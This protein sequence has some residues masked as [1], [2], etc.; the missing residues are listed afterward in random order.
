MRLERGEEVVSKLKELADKENIKLASLRAIGAVDEI[1]LGWYD[2]ENQEY[3][4]KMLHGQWEITSL[5]GSI[6]TMQGEPYLHLHI[7]VSNESYQAMGGHLESA[8]I[9]GSFEGIIWEHPG[10]VER[11]PDPETG[12]NVLKLSD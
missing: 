5:M 9:S 2:V 1:T 3:R 7:T 6:T 11:V 10:T 12:L 4:S 8:R